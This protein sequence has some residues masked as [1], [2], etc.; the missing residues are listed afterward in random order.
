MARA[1]ALVLLGFVLLGCRTSAETLIG[2]AD[3]RDIFA[4]EVEIQARADREGISR[5]EAIR[6]LRREHEMR[7]A[8]DLQKEWKSKNGVKV[9]GAKIHSKIDEPDTPDE[10][11]I[12]EFITSKQ[13]ARAE[14]REAAEIES[15]EEAT[16]P[17]GD[18]DEANEDAVDE[19]AVKRA[20]LDA[21]IGRIG[22]PPYR[23]GLEPSER[24][25][26]WRVLPENG[27]DTGEEAATAR[28]AEKNRRSQVPAGQAPK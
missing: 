5:T 20:K 9:E 18:A 15:D 3:G 27:S 21:A 23:G 10:E 22:L 1:G 4:T 13:T 28:Q 24:S 26:G 16:D 14:A 25:E 17:E 7:V 12:A 2:R 11:K 6:E 8:I 19:D